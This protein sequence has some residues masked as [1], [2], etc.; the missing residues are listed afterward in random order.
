MAL[1]L[2]RDSVWRVYAWCDEDNTCQ[3]QEFLAQLERADPKEHAVLQ[4]RITFL[5]ERGSNYRIKE[6]C[7]HLGDGV[8][9][10]KTRRGGIRMY[11]FFD[12]DRIV[13]CTHAGLRPKSSTGVNEAKAYVLRIRQE[14]HR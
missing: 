2:I 11:F 4:R 13:V 9:E 1:H 10:L 5:A 12:A 3:V 7:R 14:Y 8:F 6:Q